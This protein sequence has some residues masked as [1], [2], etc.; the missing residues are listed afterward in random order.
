MIYIQDNEKLF[1]KNDSSSENSESLDKTESRFE[2]L[3]GVK[4][5]TENNE[6]SDNKQTNANNEPKDDSVVLKSLFKMMKKMFTTEPL[7]AQFLL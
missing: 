2:K 5:S 7:K 6:S 4:N 3:F 1:G